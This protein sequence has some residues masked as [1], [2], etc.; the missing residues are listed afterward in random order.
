MELLFFQ[1]QE[2]LQE[3]L[4]FMA[5]PI[6]KISIDDQ[7]IILSGEAKELYLLELAEREATRLS[8][9]QQDKAKY[10]AKLAAQAKL[11]ALGF[12]AEDLKALGL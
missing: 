7:E 6:L 3:G 2:Q 8:L 12:T 4:E 11:A 10:E 5:T 1:I 9:E